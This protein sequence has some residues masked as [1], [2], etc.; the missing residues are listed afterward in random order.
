[1]NDNH[2]LRLFSMFLFKYK[3]PTEA[4]S[5]NSKETFLSITLNGLH[6]FRLR[7][8]AKLET[9]AHQYC[10]LELSTSDWIGEEKNQHWRIFLVHSFTVFCSYILIKPY[11]IIHCKHWFLDIQFRPF[12]VLTSVNQLRR[13]KVNFRSTLERISSTSYSQR[14]SSNSSES[15]R[16]H[17][18]NLSQSDIWM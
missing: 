17:S 4:I 3:H 15:A 5:F 14:T 7:L 8:V 6:S 10:L 18:H 16:L 2:F 12:M 1:M 11:D 13:R 9:R